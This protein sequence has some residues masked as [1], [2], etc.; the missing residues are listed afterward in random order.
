MSGEGALGSLDDLIRANGCQAPEVARFADTLCAWS[1]GEVVHFDGEGGPAVAPP[2]CR[3]GGQ[4]GSVEPDDGDVAGRGDVQR[5]AVAADEQR[6]AVAERA[7]LGKRELTAGDHLSIRWLRELPARRCDHLACGRALGRSG[8]DD[9]SAPRIDDGQS[10]DQGGERFE[11]PAPERVSRA[12]MNH[13]EPMLGR[14]ARGAQAGVHLVCGVGA[15]A[16]RDR[17]G[18]AARRLDAERRQ[19]VPLV[20]HRVPRPEDPWPTDLRGVHPATAHDVV[21]DPGCGA[22][23]PGEE[24]GARATMKINGQIESCA[25]QPAD[26]GT[27]VAQS[28]EAPGSR[29]CND[30]FVQ[31]WVAFEDR[32]G[33]RFDQVAERGLRE[34]RTERPEGWRGEDDVA[35]LPEAN[36]QDAGRANPPCRG[37]VLDARFVDQHDWNVVLDRIDALT[38]P[39]LERRAVLHEGDGRFAART[40]QNV[41]QI[42]VD[43]H[44]GTI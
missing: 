27:L 37:L 15:D 10:G 42:G 18:V 22:T 38:G 33:G 16:H 31:V 12:D 14:H 40:R 43:R 19:Q 9:N 17:I 20:L 5:T 44:D 11:R 34:P 4:R 7:E 1:A 25:A 28:R 35:N 39:A 2:R 41:E 23:Q 24:R 8:G 29:W 6:R 32:G 13:D 3:S 36:E 21:A 26:E 30:D